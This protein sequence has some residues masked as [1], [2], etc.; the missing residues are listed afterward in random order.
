VWIVNRDG[1]FSVVQDERVKSRVLVRGR[2]KGDIENVIQAVG[3]IAEPVHTPKSDYPWRISIC[4]ADFGQYLLTYTEGIDYPN[5]KNKVFDDG[6][7]KKRLDVLHQVWAVLRG[8]DRRRT[9]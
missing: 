6:A 5:F 9:R 2:R 7:D 8:L 3:Y 1:F 4:K